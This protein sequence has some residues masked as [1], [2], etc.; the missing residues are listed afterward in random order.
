MSLCKGSLQ[1][2]KRREEVL[3][4]SPGVRDRTLQGLGHQQP[5]RQE[6]FRIKSRECFEKELSSHTWNTV[7]LEVRRAQNG[8]HW[9]WPQDRKVTADHK[10]SSFCAGGAW[11]QGQAGTNGR[12]GVGKGSQ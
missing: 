3:R 5:E 11:G 1:R 7:S 6:A 10:M 8:V 12:G 4:A 2:E 9:I